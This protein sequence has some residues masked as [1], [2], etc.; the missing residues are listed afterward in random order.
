MSCEQFTTGSSVMRMD[1]VSF[2]LAARCL[3]FQAAGQLKLRQTRFE[4]GDAIT[5]YR[6]INKIH[7]CSE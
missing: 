3:A 5:A 4:H 7:K 2:S 6:D 1:D